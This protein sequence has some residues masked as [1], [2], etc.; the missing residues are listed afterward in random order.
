MQIFFTESI[1]LK[2]R[3]KTFLPDVLPKNKQTNKLVF[4]PSPTNSS[5]SHGVL[6][7]LQGDIQLQQ[8]ERFNMFE[9]TGIQFLE[10]Q[11]ARL[12]DA[13]IYTCTVVNSAGKASVSAE[14]TVQGTVKTD[15]QESKNEPLSLLW[16]IFGCVFNINV[17]FFFHLTLSSLDG[18]V[19]AWSMLQLKTLCWFNVNEQS[20]CFFVITFYKISFPFLLWFWSSYVLKV[21]FNFS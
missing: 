4:S 16:K 7:Y 19:I 2:D 9:K 8:S 11:N 12:A 3:R 1:G 5:L 10:I 15:P 6:W 13:G 18:T 20:N 17:Y 14:L 21:E